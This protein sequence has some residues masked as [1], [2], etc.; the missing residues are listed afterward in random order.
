MLIVCQRLNARSL[1]PQLTDI[2]MKRSKGNP[3]YVVEVASHLKDNGFIEVL[4]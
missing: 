4:T 3:L 2:I 1:D